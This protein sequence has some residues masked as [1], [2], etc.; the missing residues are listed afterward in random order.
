M[1]LLIQEELTACLKC[2]GKEFE[3]RNHYDKLNLWEYSCKACGQYHT[4]QKSITVI[5]KDAPYKGLGKPM[6]LPPW[7]KR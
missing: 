4:A 3:L 2:G 6:G 1:S 7:R 5:A